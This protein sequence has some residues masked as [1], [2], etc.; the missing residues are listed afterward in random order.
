MVTQGNWAILAAE[1][2]G[3]KAGRDA[4]GVTI[5][6][7]TNMITQTTIRYVR[8]VIGNSYAPAYQNVMIG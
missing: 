3:R 1:Q 6:I 2:E 8:K 5:T 4:A 7:L